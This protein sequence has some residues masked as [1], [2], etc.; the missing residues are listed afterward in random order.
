MSLILAYPADLFHT[1]KVD[2]DFIEEAQHLASLGFPILRLSENL[3]PINPSILKSSSASILY[4]GWM[5]SATQYTSLHHQLNSRLL[6][7]PQT[8]LASHYILNWIQ[9]L[10]AAQLTAATTIIPFQDIP[11]ILNAFDSLPPQPWFVKDYVKSLKTTP[12]PIVANRQELQA[13]LARMEQ[14]R[15]LIEGGIALRELQHFQPHTEQRFFVA[16]GRLFGNTTSLTTEE[17]SRLQYAITLLQTQHNRPFFSLDIARF[18]NN[19]HLTIIE[20]GDGQVSDF[21]ADSRTKGL[22]LSTFTHVV[23]HLATSCT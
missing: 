15:G 14:Y 6:V 5:L 4:R 3:A 23:Q 21:S 12:G 18:V 9:P 13:C 10:S 22:D 7:N 1:H 16:N 8:Y 19:G 20:I 17:L 11:S 2:P